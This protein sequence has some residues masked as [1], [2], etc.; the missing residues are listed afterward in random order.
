VEEVS[1]EEALRYCRAVGGRLPTEAEWEYAA[2]AG[3]TK[4]RDD[5]DEF[6]LERT[7]E[8]AQHEANALGLYD[9]LG[10][11]WE[12]TADWYGGYTASSSVDP[13][14]PISGQLRAARGGQGRARASRRLR[15][16]PDL[17]NY[18]IGLRCVG[19]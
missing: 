19:G 17:P 3:S 7:H 8:V 16:S 14:G 5:I 12:W 11:V 15:A 6:W 13:A 4:S 1:W 9:M 10:N 18:L 2:R